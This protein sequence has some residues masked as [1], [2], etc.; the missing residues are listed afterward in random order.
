ME[1]G[2]AMTDDEKPKAV[3]GEIFKIYVMSPPF[4]CPCGYERKATSPIG[5]MTPHVPISSDTREQCPA[6][7]RYLKKA[8]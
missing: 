3:V 6:C 5:A 1:R 4:L 8:P 7:G 2:D